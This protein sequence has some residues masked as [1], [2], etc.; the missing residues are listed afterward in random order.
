MRSIVKLAV[1]IALAAAVVA[2]LA[3]VL[4]NGSAATTQPQTE[5]SAT[6]PSGSISTEKENAV[7]TITYDKGMLAE[8]G[9]GIMV[10]VSIRNDGYTNFRATASSFVFTA[11][12]VT[13]P[14]DYS[15]TK[16]LSWQNTD[17]P[18]G[19]SYNATIV[20]KGSKLPSS[21]ALS[22][23]S[24]STDYNIVCQPK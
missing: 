18:D 20:F 7:I 6:L 8:C 16:T 10:A 14:Y 5:N 15:A 3:F 11:N 13:L 9:T 4:M 19:G 22:Y 21:F 23:N 17:I 12:G 24:G 2:S 1:A